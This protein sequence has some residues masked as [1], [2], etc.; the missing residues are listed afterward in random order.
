MKKVFCAFCGKHED[1][2]D[3]IVSGQ[4]PE[5]HICDTCVDRAHEFIKAEYSLHNEGMVVDMHSIRKGDVTPDSLKKYLD[6]YVVGQE[7][8]KRALCVAVYNHYKRLFM[9]QYPKNIDD[10][11]EVE[12]SNVFLV[13][14]TGVGKTLLA[15]TI[16]KKLKVPFHSVSMTQMTQA[17][18]VGE[19][20]E[21]ALSGLLQAADG[22]VESAQMG[23][24][25]MDEAD[26]IARKGDNPSL[27]RDV[28]GEGVQQALLKI[29]EGGVVNVPPNG[30]R[31]HPD[32]KLI[33]IDTTNILFIFGGAFEG[34]DRLIER[35]L[36]MRPLGFDLKTKTLPNVQTEDI[37]AYV[38][39][40][41]L[42]AYGLIPEL[43][44]RIPVITHLGPLDKTALLKVLTQPKNALIKQ[45]K[46]LMAM[47]GINLMFTN[48]ALEYI[49]NKALELKVGAR[50][51]RSIC[52]TIMQ[53]AMF[54]LPSQKNVKTYEVDG[55]YARAKF[56]RPKVASLRVA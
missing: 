52:E 48:D 30:G 32:Q 8:A 29:I 17:G 2:V 37:G 42:K 21:S 54:D 19:D 56:E 33:P 15:S 18:Y 13:G 6:Q 22:N 45:Y 9:T 12:K 25:Y 24:I 4:V 44:G 23:V 34:I 53:D 26:K 10:G 50:G 7:I 43:V 31:R 55:K 11:V 38:S 1:E 39:A 5:A 51:L 40:Q 3:T 27:T 49:V 36:H 35:R 20:V 16:A 41:D 46:K 47:E 14:P 28:G